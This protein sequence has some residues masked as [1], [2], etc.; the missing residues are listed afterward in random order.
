MA[1]ESALTNRMKESVNIE[2]FI[3]HIIIKGEDEP[4]FLARVDLEP[5]QV[6]FFKQRIADAS[7]GTQYNFRE[8]DVGTSL[9]C[10]RM[11]Q[12]TE[13]LF[14]PE[15][16]S[17]AYDFHEL[18]RG[19]VND[20]ALIVSLF[21]IDVDGGRVPMIAMIKMDHSRVLEYK[22]N[23][24]AA[25]QVAT[26]NEILNSFIESKS[27]VQK[28]AV[29]DVGDNFDW[30]V[31]A[32]ERGKAIGIADYFTA[33]LKVVE[34]DNAS[35][36]TRKAVATVTTW[37]RTNRAD[38]P[39][40]PRYYRVRAAQYMEVHDHFDTDSFV[41]M[42]VRDEDPERKAHLMGTLHEQ[43]T[44]TGVAG[45]RFSPR[46]DS[47]PDSQKTNKISTAEQVKITWQGS[48]EAANINIVGPD[49][50]GMYDIH[51]R[52]LDYSDS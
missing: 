36:L 52:T 43:L 5:N 25:G 42:V 20:G 1:K 24:E 17:L 9:R 37:A 50:F 39:E 32:Y 11:V 19:N 28:C 14:L 2:K 13:Q 30:D 33:F 47:V 4:R 51:I 48:E 12:D 10:E 31:L 44:E 38:L 21:S 7:E 18:H 16:R 29:V 26:M 15:S 34:S 41:D 3:F 40:S 45:Q 22:I 27:A 6:E 8:R 35:N 46:P 23:Q 49:D